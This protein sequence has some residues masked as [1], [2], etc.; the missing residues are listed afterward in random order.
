MNEIFS[1]Q[2]ANRCDRNSEIRHYPRDM[3]NFC[4]LNEIK[5]EV[6]KI[7]G[8]MQSEQNLK[9]RRLPVGGEFEANLMKR[10]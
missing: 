7:T 9:W 8:A 10:L 3:G 5:L 6:A 1:G 2:R 4:A